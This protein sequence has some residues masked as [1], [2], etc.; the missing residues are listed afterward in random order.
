MKF[1]LPLLFLIPQPAFAVNYGKA[2]QH[3]NDNQ[4][5]GM[6]M[7]HFAGITVILVVVVGG[8]MWWMKNKD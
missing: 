3:Y 4:N 6:E 8:A 7:I 2:M 5:V 1:L